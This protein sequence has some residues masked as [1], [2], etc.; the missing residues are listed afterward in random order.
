[1]VS[2][3]K[4]KKK[5]NLLI[6][7]DDSEISQRDESDGSFNEFSESSDESFINSS[8]SKKK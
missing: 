8:F 6:N 1:M 3:F 5:I 2:K 4:N 7:S